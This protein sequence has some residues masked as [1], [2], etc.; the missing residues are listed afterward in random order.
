MAQIMVLFRLKKRFHK[1][2]ISTTAVIKMK[3]KTFRF[4]ADDAMKVTKSEIYHAMNSPEFH[5]WRPELDVQHLNRPAKRPQELEGDGRIAAVLLL[6]FPEEDQ[7]SIVLTKRR[8]DLKHHPGQISFPGGKQEPQ[9]R[10]KQTALRESQEEVGVDPNQI[11]VVGQCNSVYVPPSDFTIFPF[12]GWLNQRPTFQKNLDEVEEIIVV[13]MSHLLQ[14]ALRSNESIHVD[15]RNL[16]VPLYQIDQ[17]QVWGA[18]FIILHELV[19]RLQST[20]R[21]G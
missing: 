21:T 13:P 2:K 9:E 12:V 6:L 10:L 18:T 4:Q 7:V 11:E 19:E 17:H 5:Q 14:G 20:L 1:I 15:G 8:H 3:R 16:T